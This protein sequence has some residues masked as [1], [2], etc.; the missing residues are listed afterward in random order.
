MSKA[1]FIRKTVFSLFLEP[2]TKHV[3]VTTLYG[4]HL[5][6]ISKYPY[7]IVTTSFTFKKNHILYLK[8]FYEAVWRAGVGIL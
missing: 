7:H 8:L 6:I 4:R 3:D 5:L 2:V 1:N